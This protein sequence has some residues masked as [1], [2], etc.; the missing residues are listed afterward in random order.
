[1]YLGRGN[2]FGTLTLCRMVYLIVLTILGIYFC[3]VIF[4]FVHVE[5]IFPSANLVM[6]KGNDRTV[7]FSGLV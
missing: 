7:N 6:C 5:S 1:M 2:N 3:W 4:L